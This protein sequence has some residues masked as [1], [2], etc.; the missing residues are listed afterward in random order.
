[1]RWIVALPASIIG[2]VIAYWFIV[3]INQITMARY[4]DPNSFMAEVFVQWL[5]NFVLGAV[6]VYISVYI[7]P[8]FKK[9]TAIVM[10][11]IA[12]LLSGAFLFTAIMTRDYWAM[13]GTVCMNV[14][15]L[16]VACGVFKN[17][18]DKEA[19]STQP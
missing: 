14:G 16:A 11:V 3:F 6:F 4:I 13:F 1:L 15:S 8:V 17:E 12:L 2:C 7:V 5:G 18:T 9:Q 19:Y 10:A